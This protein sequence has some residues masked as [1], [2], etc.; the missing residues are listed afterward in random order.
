MT[1]L[2]KS[3]ALAALALGLAISAL[4]VS[5]QEAV[6]K[7]K[8]GFSNGVG[9]G[10]NNTGKAVKPSDPE[11]AKKQAE[12]AAQAQALVKLYEEKGWVPAPSLDA[13]DDP[14]HL[15]MRRLFDF[16]FR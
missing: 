5:A 15:Q 9:N 2:S 6:A 10:A 12:I 7:E 16:A 3:L 13:R 14:N 1:T 8:T 4:P 11:E